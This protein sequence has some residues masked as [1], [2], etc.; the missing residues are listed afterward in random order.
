MWGLNEMTAKAYLHTVAYS[1]QEYVLAPPHRSVL[2]G[3]LGDTEN[4]HWLKYARSIARIP[5]PPILQIGT[6][7]L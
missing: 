3:V 5:K 1:R 4:Q 7:R 2:G 6:L